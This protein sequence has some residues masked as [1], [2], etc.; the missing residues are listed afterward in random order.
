MAN[1]DVI[2]FALR[3]AQFLLVYTVAAIAAWSYVPRRHRGFW[4]PLRRDW[5]AAVRWGPALAWTVLTGFIAGSLFLL[6]RIPVVFQSAT[7]IPVDDNLDLMAFEMLA[8]VS[9]LP[10]LL[11]YVLAWRLF[12]AVDW[13]YVAAAGLPLAQRERLLSY[14]VLGGGL[15]W[16]LVLLATALFFG[17]GVIHGL[18]R[19]TGVDAM[20]EPWA[21]YGNQIV[22]LSFNILLPILVYVR[23][24]EVVRRMMWRMEHAVALRWVEPT[25]AS[26]SIENGAAS[27]PVERAEPVERAAAALPGDDLRGVQ[28]YRIFPALTEAATRRLLLVWLTGG[29]AGGVIGILQLLRAVW[30]VV[31]A[32]NTNLALSLVLT[33]L[34]LLA[35]GLGVRLARWVDWAEVSR[36]LSWRSSLNGRRLAILALGSWLVWPFELAQ[37]LLQPQLDS[38][39]DGGGGALMFQLALLAIAG[40]LIAYMIFVYYPNTPNASDASYPD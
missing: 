33:A 18:I 38:S 24:C 1:N 4:W 34:P 22:D 15:A 32:P 9:V 29:L 11:S 39:N 20:L 40:A 37:K 21:W 3:N 6:L 36:F 23:S 19:G 14:L 27:G 17:N 7:S 16:P 8:V 10:V 28:L 5:P 25:A 30:G 26:P 2:G 31:F 12:K 13:D 35:Y